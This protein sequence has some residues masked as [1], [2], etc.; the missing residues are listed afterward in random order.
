VLCPDETVVRQESGHAVTWSGVDEW[1]AAVHR[2]VST[3]TA[4]GG[5]APQQKEKSDASRYE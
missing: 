4:P 1:L 2:T 3:K 5:A